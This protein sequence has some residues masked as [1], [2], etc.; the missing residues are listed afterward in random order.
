MNK[1]IFYRV[2]ISIITGFL[3]IWLTAFAVYLS[4]N[5]QPKAEPPQIQA[6]SAQPQPKAA[7]PQNETADTPQ[8]VSASSIAYYLAVIQNGRIAIYEMYTNGSQQLRTILEDI[9][10]AMLRAEDRKNFEKGMRLY[11]EEDLASLIE[12]FSS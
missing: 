11:S 7:V 5:R 8:A 1:Q 10:P 4:Q 6:P 3:I 12:D 9:D 2:S